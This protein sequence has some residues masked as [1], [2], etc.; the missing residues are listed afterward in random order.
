MSLR[1]KKKARRE[2]PE[3]VLKFKLDTCS[4]CRDVVEG[5]RLYDE[6]RKNGVELN[7][8]HYNVLL[9]LCSQNGARLASAMEDPEMAFILVKQMKSFGILPKLRS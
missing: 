1:E 2:A 7:Q 9:Y 8:H 5:L 4:K 6:A 3:R